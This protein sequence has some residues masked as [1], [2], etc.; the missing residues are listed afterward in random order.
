MKLLFALA[1]VLIVLITSAGLVFAQDFPNPVG[2]VNDFAGLL[3]AGVRTQLE[4]RLGQLEQDTTAEVAVVTI[5]TLEGN[6]IEYY[7][8]ELFNEWG[9]GQ[10]GEDNG[11]LFLVAL[12]ERQTRIE[13][14][15][16]LEGVI[17][18]GRAGRILDQYVIPSFKNSNYEEGII[19][20]VTAIES[21]IRG[22]IPPSLVEENPI[23][24]FVNQSDLWIPVLFVLGFISIYLLRW[25]ART[26]SFWLG[27]VWGVICGLA[28]GFALSSLA[29]IIGLSVG[30]GVFGTFLDLLLSRNYK[31]RKAS[32]KPTNWT[33]SW[34]GFSSGGGGFSSHGGGF[35]GG[36]SGGGGA[37]RGW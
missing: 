13:V 18:D 33:R 20:G 16:G 17:T 1:A 27:G 37:G 23:S 12:E 25:M 9:I 10:K 19:A 4:T 21:Y 6:P 15:Y 22:D 26:K 3:S 29:A 7:A 14:G 32:G 8:N 34:G 5:N 36:H 28:L 30:L 35:G 2:Y 11:I 24:D 31:T